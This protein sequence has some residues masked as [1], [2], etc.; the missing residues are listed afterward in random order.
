MY[1]IPICS[2]VCVAMLAVILWR[3]EESIGRVVLKVLFPKREFGKGD[4]I[5]IY[6]NDD[7]NR[8]AHITGLSESV[9]SI[10]DKLALPIGYRSRF[11][12]IGYSPDGDKF[13]YVGDK[14]HYRFVRLAEVMRKFFEISD[15][16][17]F[18]PDDEVEDGDETEEA[19]D[20]EE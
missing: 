12:A 11:Y 9:V 7:Y 20:D 18:M 19:D 1:W 8:K 13:V 14:R 17:N 4:L 3:Y 16:D 6:V 5:H 15:Y 2:I 10:Y